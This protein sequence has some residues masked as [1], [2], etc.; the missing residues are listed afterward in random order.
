[1]PYLTGVVMPIQSFQ[2]YLHSYHF[3]FPSCYLWQ[4]CLCSYYYYESGWLYL[5]QVYQLLQVQTGAIPAAAGLTNLV[6][7]IQDGENKIWPIGWSATVVAGLDT[8][9]LDWMD[10]YFCF[11]TVHQLGT[12]G[13]G[14]YMWAYMLDPFVIGCQSLWVNNQGKRLP[15]FP[16]T[17]SPTTYI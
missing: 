17:Q 6:N 5:F 2:Q 3:M 13:G 16:L 15:T 1:M 4:V 10:F 7:T 8:V 14:V 11:L 12:G 9:H